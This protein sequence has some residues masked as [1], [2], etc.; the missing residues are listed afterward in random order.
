M[1]KRNY[2]DSEE[3]EFWA[4]TYKEEIA[5]N[6]NA[7]K[8]LH[9]LLSEK[10]V[11]KIYYQKKEKE[12]EKI[13]FES[14]QKLVL[15]VKLREIGNAIDIF[16][17]QTLVV[18][19]T[20]IES[21]LEEFVFCVFC[22]SPQKMYEYLH[23]GDEKNKGKIDLKEILESISQE[24]LLVSLARKAA[25]RVMQ[26]EFKNTVKKIKKITTGESFPKNLLDAMIALNIAR[27]KIVHELSRAETPYDEVAK[28]FEIA[29]KLLE[30]LKEISEQLGI[31][32]ID[33]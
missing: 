32:V 10:E 27:N 2:I 18:L 15:L 7:Y 1:S 29:N 5:Q 19:V 6:F 23:D 31:T 17:R 22:A 33:L 4:S 13:E 16:N 9:E 11:R 20:I 14:V 21:M 28:A 26:G 3:Y 25:S 8:S 12:V 24:D 30:Y